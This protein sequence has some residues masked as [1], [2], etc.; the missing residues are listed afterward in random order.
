MK[1]IK[2][3]GQDSA[4]K[5]PQKREPWDKQFTSPT[6]GLKQVGRVVIAIVL[7]LLILEIIGQICFGKVNL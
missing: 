3:L 2:P 6:I 4:A 7:V 1:K 5:Q